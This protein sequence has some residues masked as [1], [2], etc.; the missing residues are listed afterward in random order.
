[1]RGYLGSCVRWGIFNKV[2][3]AFSRKGTEV[4]TS[5]LGPRLDSAFY[6]QHKD[7]TV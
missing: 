7:Q 1:M 3:E 4:A 2:S 5:A 6:L